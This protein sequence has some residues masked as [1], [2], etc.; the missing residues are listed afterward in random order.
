MKKLVLILAI[1]FGTVS[2]Y[3]QNHDT[4]CNGC[5]K[6]YCFDVV[7]YIGGTPTEVLACQHPNMTT[8]AAN[9]HDSGYYYQPI[10]GVGAFSS[11]L[12]ATVTTTAV[13]ASSIIQVS[14]YSNE[15]D[16]IGL[17]VPS[18]TVAAG[19]QFV[20][21]ATH[22]NS[23]SFYYVIPGGINPITGAYNHN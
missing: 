20:I 10:L 22:S 18:A 5:T 19:S 12:T 3:A 16:T 8:M 4:T 7:Q 2:G 23:D 9:I 1:I 17:Y 15:V 11:A 13:A 6:P 14:W 21:K